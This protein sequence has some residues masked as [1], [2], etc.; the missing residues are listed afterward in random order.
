MRFACDKC[1][2]Q[3]AIDDAKIG[4]KGVK[5]R[6]KR[7]GNV[8]TLQPPAAAP[9]ADKTIVD[10]QISAPRPQQEAASEP[11]G[12]GGDEI[13]KALDAMFG[14]EGPADFSESAG[15]EDEEGE[16][17]DRQATRVFD[18]EAMQRVQKEKEQASQHEPSSGGLA[19]VYSAA[20]AEEKAA[21]TASPAAPPEWYL[22]V[23][24]RQLGPLTIDEVRQRLVSGDINA[25]TMAWKAGFSDWKSIEDIEELRSLL[26]A[27]KPLVESASSAAPFGQAQTEESDFSPGRM[28][29]EEFGEEPPP[30]QPQEEESGDFLGG[31]RQI[32]Y[33]EA[34][35]AALSGTG[36]DWVPQGLSEL[37]KLAEQEL[38]FLKPKEEEPPPE[39][40]EQAKE[41]LDSSPMDDGDSSIIEKL[42]RE[43]QEEAAREEERRREEQRLA[44]EAA[45]REKERELAAQREAQMER[46]REQK[47]KA[48]KPPE[49]VIPPPPVHAGLPRWLVWG[50]FGLGAVL[51]ILLGVVAYKLFTVPAPVLPQVVLAPGMAQPQVAVT[52]QP[53]SP[54]PVLPQAAQP[55]PAVQPP[56]P[57]QPEPVPNPV[58][59]PAAQPAQPLMAA[60]Q[61]SAPAVNVPAEKKLPPPAPPARQMGGAATK[62]ATAPKA[63]KEKPALIEEKE[64]P[65][66]PKEPPRQAKSKGGLLDFEDEAAFEKVTGGSAAAAPPVAE[67]PVKKELPPLTNADVLEVMKQHLEEF[68]ACNRKQQQ[69]DDSVKGKMVVKI[70]IKPDGRVAQV[71]I[72]TPEFRNTVVAECISNVIKLAR[73]PEFGGG[74]TTVPFPFTV[75]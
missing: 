54:Q 47:E 18:L 34:E 40:I 15:D 2:A 60:A 7:C 66:P 23:D 13:G 62:P 50:G 31:G 46:E 6:C 48:S 70:T 39:S 49:Q 58:P 53:L 69:A 73:F 10:Q 72:D 9:A 5:V 61:P 67:K 55:Q 57:A 45:R 8:I 44:E 52:A 65:P 19:A 27:K 22:A 36:V 41:Q 42:A 11:P 14:R 68:K 16:D 71:A 30:Q 28:P 20:A 17:L 43:Q 12:E 38:S 75:K 37:E 74:P 25:D 32:D 26:K 51:V 33:D 56:Q 1:N 63:A 24:E 3:Y 4:P 64:P 21:R 35:N 59:A 29:E